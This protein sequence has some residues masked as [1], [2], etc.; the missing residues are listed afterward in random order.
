MDKNGYEKNEFL[1]WIKHLIVINIIENSMSHKSDT[2]KYFKVCI[3]SLRQSLT[4]FNFSFWSEILWLV[5]FELIQI[6]K[7]V[8]YLSSKG[9][10]IIQYKQLQQ[11][12]K[13]NSFAFQSRIFLC[14]RF[15]YWHYIQSVPRSKTSQFHNVNKAL[16]HLWGL[17]Y[18]CKVK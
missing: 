14:W 3:V 11:Q 7:K 16:A 2:G 15:F 18:M 10:S 6:L 17:F 4:H 12:N 5:V 8:P 9:R 13:L 1:K